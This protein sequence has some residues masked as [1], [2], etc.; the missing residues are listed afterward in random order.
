MSHPGENTPV[1]PR[2]GCQGLASSRACEVVDRVRP[3]SL[4]EPGEE[5]QQ[6]AIGV[7]GLLRRPGQEVSPHIELFRLPDGLQLGPVIPL[8][9][10]YL[11]RKA[12]DLNHPASAMD[13]LAPGATHP[14]QTPG[15]HRR[16]HRHT[17]GCLGTSLGA[18]GRPLG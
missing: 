12:L 13:M 7:L 5:G 10:E 9:L 18:D 16:G 14:R 2:G 4:I 17:P 1:E 6:Q 3:P 15:S 8:N 11:L